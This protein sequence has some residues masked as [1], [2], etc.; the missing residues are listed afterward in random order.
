MALNPTLILIGGL[1]PAVC[2]RSLAAT[3]PAT[4]CAQADVQVAINAARAGDTVRLPA[5]TATWTKELRVSKGIYL[6]GDGAGGF[7]GHSRTRLAVG[8]G[9]KAFI[10]QAGLGFQA[11]QTVR[12]LYVADGTRFLV[13]TVTSYRGT[14]LQ[15]QVTSNRGSGTLGAWVFALPARTTLINDAANDWGRAMID[16]AEDP[17][18]S[19]EIS[20]I[21]FRSGTA[22]YGA[23]LNL[24][25]TAGGKPVV[26]HDCWFPHGGDIGRAIWEKEQ[27][28][29]EPL[30]Y[31]A[32]LETKPG[33]LDYARPLAGWTLPECFA[34][35]RRRLEA[36]REG[37]GTP[38]YIR[39][40]RLLEQHPLPTLRAAV[41]A[42]LPP[43]ASWR[44]GRRPPAPSSSRR[45]PLPA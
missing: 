37:D 9:A 13:G 33:A 12:A 6:E 19:L 27:V 40:L 3:I 45:R 41:E 10:T 5:G 39:V 23:H 31:L 44:F 35:L 20:G 36:E 29:F 38:E 14:N 42:A 30:H 22:T 32:L 43:G 2:V 8:L 7:V 25:R 15:M 11:G 16:V 24:R 21:R 1:L 34:L 26:I 18:A 4:S 28:C 17:A